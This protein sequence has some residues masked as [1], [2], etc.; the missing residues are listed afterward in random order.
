[1]IKYKNKQG[2]SSRD[3]LLQIHC[4]MD[5]CSLNLDTAGCWHLLGLHPTSLS[6]EGMGEH[7]CALIFLCRKPDHSSRAQC[8]VLLALTGGNCRRSPY[9][10][11]TTYMLSR[12]G[13]SVSA[14]DTSSDLLQTTG[15]ITLLCPQQFVFDH[16]RTCILPHIMFKKA[17]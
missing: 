5:I 4:V 7:N 11:L 8:C 12:S 10:H 15:P 16:S 13:C 6:R 2:W 3:L 14:T 17:I 1:M 9:I